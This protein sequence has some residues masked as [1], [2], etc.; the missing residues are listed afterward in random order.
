MPSVITVPVDPGPPEGW[1][2]VVLWG[3]AVGLA[4]LI[5]FGIRQLIVRRS[6]VL[7]AATIGGGLCIILEPFWDVL[8]LGL[9][10]SNGVPTSVSIAGRTL[11]LWQ[12][13][14]YFAYAGLTCYFFYWVSMTGL[15][16]RRVR[17]AVLGTF[18]L[19]L[20][21]ELPITAMGVYEYFGP[22]PFNPTGFPLW[23]LFTNAGGMLSGLVIAELV[24]RKG[25]W[26]GIA[27][28]LIVPSAFGGWEMMTGWPIYAALSSGKGL[29]VTYPAAVLTAALSLALMR[30]VYE[31]ASLVRATEDSSDQRKVTT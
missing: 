26:A 15:T 8:G 9:F 3:S 24:R 22:Q 19:N 30:G 5:A 21:I 29:W 16:A 31:V 23:W 11:P 27:A 14:A 25:Q 1:H 10:Y 13:F 28:V 7:L 18:A 20:A 2:T 17:N 6:P 4:V 12:F